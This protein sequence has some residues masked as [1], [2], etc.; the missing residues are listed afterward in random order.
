MDAPA[1]RRSPNLFDIL[2]ARVR[3]ASDGQLVIAASLGVLGL[4]TLFLLRR[5]PWPAVAACGL[6]LGAGVWG[7]LDRSEDPPSLLGR[8]LPPALLITARILAGS[9]GLVSLLVL[10]LGGFGMCLGTW[11]S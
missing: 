10:L 3:A 1:E 11:I 7:I 6:L 4:A 9:V 2:R 8:R 5:W